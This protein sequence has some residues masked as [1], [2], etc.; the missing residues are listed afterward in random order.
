MTH[1]RALG[2]QALCT[3]LPGKVE[4]RGVEQGLEKI[5]TLMVSGHIGVL[6]PQG[7]A[8]LGRCSYR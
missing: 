4:G 5:L 3:G 8:V 6:L 7:S 1:T 2:A